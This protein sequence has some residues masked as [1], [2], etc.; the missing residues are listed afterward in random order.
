MPTTIMV[1]GLPELVD[2]PYARE[3]I[4]WHEQGIVFPASKL[5]EK[6]GEKEENPPADNLPKDRE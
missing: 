1:Q 4:K 3:L 6:S 5:L 2:T